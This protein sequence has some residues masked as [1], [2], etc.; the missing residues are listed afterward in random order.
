MR[1]FEGGRKLF[2]SHLDPQSFQWLPRVVVL[3]YMGFFGHDLAKPSHILGNFRA[4]QHLGR[5]LSKADRIRFSERLVKRNQLRVRKNLQPQIYYQKV[6]KRDGSQGWQ[7]G[8]ALA[9]SA[10]YTPH[11]AQAMYHC[12]EAEADV[13]P[14]MSHLT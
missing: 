2:L 14:T 5:T 8:R 3:T 13:P 10:H 9:N 7:G 1:R 12:W 11:F 6:K 4:L